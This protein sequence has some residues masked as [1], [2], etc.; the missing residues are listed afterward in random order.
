MKILFICKH[1]RFRSRVAE[2]IFIKLDKGKNEVK[3][4]GI[5]MNGL[6]Q[7]VAKNTYDIMKKKKY[8]IG[9]EPAKLIT[10]DAIDWADKI[11]VVADDVV[12]TNLLGL[13]KTEQWQIEDCGEDDIACIRKTID[14]I[15]KH[16]K[17]L[18]SKLNK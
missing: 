2:A 10:E 18:V 4:V 16:V 15:E 8:E 14:N 12:D 6:R 13:K 1:N 17:E 7:F 5:Q 3:S 9:D 11:I